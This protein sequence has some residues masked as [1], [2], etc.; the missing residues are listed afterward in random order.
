MSDV[1]C[2]RSGQ[3]KKFKVPKVQSSKLRNR[4]QR[5]KFKIESAKLRE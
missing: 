3:R 4:R 2:Q 1:R 5:K